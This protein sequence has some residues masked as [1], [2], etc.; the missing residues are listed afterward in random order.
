MIRPHVQAKSLNGA[1]LDITKMFQWN[2]D[3]VVF[4]M[5]GRQQGMIRELRD[6]VIDI[7][8][9]RCNVL[10]VP[11]RNM[12]RKYAAAEFALYMHKTN[13]VEAFSHYAKRW[14]DLA[15]KGAEISSAYGHR[16]FTERQYYSGAGDCTKV[17]RFD[18]AIQ[19]LVENQDSKN[20]VIMMR[21]DSDMREGL[22]D[23]CCT[24]YIQFFIRDGALDCK[25][26]MRSSD[27]WF[28][29]PYDIFWYT[30]LQQIALYT[31][32]KKANKSVRLGTFTMEC[33]SLHVYAAQWEQVK[34]AELPAYYNA[35]A[36]YEFPR[37]DE[38][39]A[40]RIKDWLNWEKV[41][42]RP[43]ITQNEIM[44]A[45]SVLRQK[46]F[47]PFLETM[48]SFLVNKINV[49]YA[50]PH[51]VALFNRA[52]ASSKES[53]CEDRKVGCVLYDEVQ[54]SLVAAYN[55]VKQ[56]NKQCD[57]KENR[58]CEVVHSEV[59]AIA[60]AKLAGITPHK[61]YVTLYPCLPCMM[62]LQLAGVKEVCV[63]GFSHKGA[64]GAVTLMDPAFT[65]GINK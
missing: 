63:L 50:K 16:I 46:Q 24:L 65:E 34:N 6:I 5:I 19:Q 12:S 27:F 53:S 17:S 20:A 30:N 49:R 39:C 37:Y 32:T 43:A 18:Y 58:V 35:D 55:Q 48:G 38:Q 52:F 3:G 9:P 23:R 59:A 56:C 4:E 36:E 31:Y 54:G 8:N 2:R 10:S 41:A 40:E 7:E 28:G 33:N 11:F 42:L 64:V 15:Y 62:A 22:K 45:A 25:V 61:A 57:D 51:E 26:V 13:D 29:L 1:Y 47:P 44:Y 14:K 21:D 60:E